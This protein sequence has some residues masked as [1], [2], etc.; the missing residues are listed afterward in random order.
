MTLALLMRLLRCSVLV[1]FISDRADHDN[2]LAKIQEVHVLFIEVNEFI[3]H[4]FCYSHWQQA[5]IDKVSNHLE[6]SLDVFA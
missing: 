5:S 6:V 3:D 4:S 1:D 2:H